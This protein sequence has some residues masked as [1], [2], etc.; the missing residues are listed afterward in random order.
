M[1]NNVNGIDSV[2]MYMLTLQFALL[3]RITWESFTKVRE[4]RRE[5]SANDTNVLQ[6]QLCVM[7]ECSHQKYT[8][9]LNVESF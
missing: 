3:G 8:C 9:Q 7:T 1:I 5:N 6:Q 2:F 4:Q